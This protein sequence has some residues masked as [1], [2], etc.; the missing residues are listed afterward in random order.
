[1][2]LLYNWRMKWKSSVSLT[3]PLCDLQV[4]ST[5]QPWNW[6]SSS[7][8]SCS[9]WPTV[10]WPP[11]HSTHGLLCGSWMYDVC[12]FLKLPTG[13]LAQEATDFSQVSD[14]FQQLRDRVTEEFSTLMN[15]PAL[16]EHAEWVAHTLGHN[17]RTSSKRFQTNSIS[18][19]FFF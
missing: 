8:P 5:Q 14:Y 10:R 19:L 17:I 9:P 11:S 2:K 1:M 6:H 18:F 16:Q 7:Q 13:S 12:V 15:N 3:E 4:L